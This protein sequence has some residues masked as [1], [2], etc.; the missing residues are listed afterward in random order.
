MRTAL[1]LCA[2]LFLLPA[3]GSTEEKRW[4]KPTAW[5]RT[6]AADRPKVL[7][8]GAEYI[9]FLSQAKTE[10]EVV[11]FATDRAAARG[12][13]PWQEGRK[14]AP[15]DRL[16]FA[17]RGKI[18]ALAVVGERPLRDGIRLVGA[19][20]DAVRIDLKPNP[21]Y[22]DTNVVLLQTHYYGGI[23]YS[24][25]QSRPLALHGVIVRKDG[26]R[27]EVRLGSDPKDPVLVIPDVL[28]HLRSHVAA[29]AGDRLPAEK[30][31]PIV[32][33]I[34]DGA[35]ESGFTSGFLSLLKSRYNIEPRDLHTAELSLVPAERPRSVGFDEGLVGGY[36]QDDRACSFAA[37]RA[38]LDLEGTP[39]HTALVILVDKEEIGSTGNTGMRSEFFRH[40][41][42]RL[43]GAQEGSFGE[44]RLRDVLAH[45]QGLSADVTS[46]VE[47]HFKKLFE[48]RNAAFLGSGPVFDTNAHA[49]FLH[50]LRALLERNKI[51]YQTGEFSKVFSGKSDEGTILPYMTRHGM[52]AANFGV[53]T[54]SMHAPLELVSK[55]DLYWAWRAYQAFLRE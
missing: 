52:D 53:P 38:I 55:V 8:F 16:L 26:T 45:S 46:G 29:E 41:V 17:S 54:L 31:D 37:L 48:R 22:A 42:G 11:A 12:F 25:W 1:A 4:F 24:Q 34:P 33:S 28:I 13:Q 36:G 50:A 32:G 39:K 15:G 6:S 20:I 49:E 51:P 10:R 23:T 27:V 43:V 47:P 21:V 2:L 30:L 19:H 40:T 9:D 3:S 18:L 7:S 5:E 14:I 35:A 44:Q